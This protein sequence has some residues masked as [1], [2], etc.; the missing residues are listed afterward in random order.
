MELLGLFLIALLVVLFPKQ[1]LK[2]I[3]LCL[4][5]GV[6]GVCFFWGYMQWMQLD[7]QR[8][9]AVIDA[10]S[11]A[12]QAQLVAE[13]QAE[14]QI[15]L[16]DEQ[17]AAELAELNRRRDEE[18]QFENDLEQKFYG[19]YSKHH[20]DAQP[21]Y[22]NPKLVPTPPPVSKPT[23]APTPKPETLYTSN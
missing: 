6:L 18:L 17:Q 3:G 20:F 8:Q 5:V 12:A 11:K 15:K 9:N 10:K 14:A 1:G 23:P 2:A 21:L 7:N 22:V 19:K 16:R 13:Q 4:G